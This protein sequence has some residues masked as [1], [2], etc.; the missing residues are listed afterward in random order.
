M[1]HSLTLQLICLWLQHS[2]HQP[3]SLSCGMQ[4]PSQQAQPVT[5]QPSPHQAAAPKM[6]RQLVHLKDLWAPQVSGPPI[7][8]QTRAAAAA[9]C[10][11]GQQHPHLPI[12]LATC[13]GGSPG[14]LLPPTWWRDALQRAGAADVCDATVTTLAAAYSCA[15]SAAAN[16][17][18]QLVAAPGGHAGGPGTSVCSAD[19]T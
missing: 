4:V 14:V 19:S 3:A 17:W 15:L 13:W 9:A 12:R 8:P 6:P 5:C 10:C 11:W 16:S 1:L 7:L 18:G 2:S